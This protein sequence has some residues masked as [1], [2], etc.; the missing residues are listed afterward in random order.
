MANV[1]CKEEGTAAPS[2]VADAITRYH[3]D[4]DSEHPELVQATK[5]SAGTLYAGGRYLLT[6]VVP[7]G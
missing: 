1:Q 6:Y 5:D 3:L 4:G 7:G 2:M